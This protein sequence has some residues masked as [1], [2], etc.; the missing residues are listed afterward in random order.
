MFV[1]VFVK[2][3]LYILDLCTTC[4]KP[5]GYATCGW[6]GYKPSVNQ[7]KQKQFERDSV[8]RQ[9]TVVWQNPTPLFNYVLCDPLS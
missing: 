9:D 8:Q 4:E 7:S 5:W 1:I 2:C 3:I 6:Q